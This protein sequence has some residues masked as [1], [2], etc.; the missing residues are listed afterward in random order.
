[1]TPLL[2]VGMASQA[3]GRLSPLVPSPNSNPI[4]E[5]P[6]SSWQAHSF[7]A[8]LQVWHQLT[9]ATMS[10]LRKS[11]SGPAPAEESV[12]G[13]ENSVVWGGVTH[14]AKQ[15]LEWP[16]LQELGGRVAGRLPGLVHMGAKPGIDEEEGSQVR[17]VVQR[18]PEVL[19]ACMVTWVLDLLLL[20]SC[21]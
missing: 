8:P 7:Q 12:T 19:P 16:G 4:T 11:G 14:A 10:R 3:A 1:M 17:R 5:A 21:R 20:K 9:A 13:S 18:L 6:S 15:V 2:H